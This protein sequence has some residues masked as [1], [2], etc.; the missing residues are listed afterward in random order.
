MKNK[1]KIIFF[2]VVISFFTGCSL[3]TQAI[4]TN[5]YTID[6]NAKHSV[7]TPMLDTIYIKKPFIKKSFDTYSIWYSTKAYH[8]EEYAINKWISK[9]SEMIYDSLVKAVETSNIFQETNPITN[10]KAIS[11][12]LKTE[13]TD[14][15]NSV[16]QDKSYAIL[17][18][19]FYLE[20]DR[21]KR[22]VFIYNRKKELKDNTP[23]SFVLAV[24]KSFE[25]SANN[26]LEIISK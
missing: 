20:K 12:T 25:E 16:E 22:K 23:Y 19:K 1:F 7:N 15:Y 4:H 8:Y 10:K 9:P 13:I 26:M 3:K 11:Y 21:K 18:I 14:I 5:K 17:K 6:F 24:N 2:V